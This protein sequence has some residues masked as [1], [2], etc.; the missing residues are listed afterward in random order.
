MISK[1]LSLNKKWEILIG[2]PI[3]FKLKEIKINEYFY[4]TNTSKT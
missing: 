1:K 3:F 4:K 2:F